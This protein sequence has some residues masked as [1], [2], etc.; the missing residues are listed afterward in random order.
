MR[1]AWLLVI[2][3]CGPTYEDVVGPFTGE[4]QRFIVDSIRVPTSGIT[5]REYGADLDGIGQ[6]DN[7]LGN[8]ITFLAGNGDVTQDGD[9]QIVSGAIQSEVLIVADDFTAEAL[10]QLPLA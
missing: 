4:T 3:A 9:D 2:A 7:Q 10:R 8:A 5:T 1:C 6:D